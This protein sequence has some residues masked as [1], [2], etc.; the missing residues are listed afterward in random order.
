MSSPA[1]CSNR[2][3]RLTETWDRCIT[4]FRILDATPFWET[5]TANNAMRD[6][7]PCSL[8]VLAPAVCL[9][10]QRHTFKVQS[11]L[12]GYCCLSVRL[13]S[14]PNP[15]LLAGPQFRMGCL[16]SGV[17]GKDVLGF[18][19]GCG[20]SQGDI[21]TGTSPH[22][23][24]TSEPTFAFELVWWTWCVNVRVRVLE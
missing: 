16:G 19:N 6:V 22:R 17:T 8:H 9:R 5:T 21:S 3:H 1:C 2:T 20:G 24:C 18:K 13:R 12:P 10:L 11:T 14:L 4:R 15:T 7:L 23:C